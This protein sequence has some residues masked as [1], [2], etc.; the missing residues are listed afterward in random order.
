MI[1]LPCCFGPET[2]QHNLIEE[3]CGRVTD[4]MASVK[5]KWAR[6]EISPSKVPLV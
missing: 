6:N 2:K 5:Q 4:L 3:T 1:S